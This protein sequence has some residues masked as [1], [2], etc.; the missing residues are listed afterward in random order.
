MH[1]AGYRD[2]RLAWT[3]FAAFTSC[4]SSGNG[5]LSSSWSKRPFF[6]GAGRSSSKSRKG[7]VPPSFL[8][9]RTRYSAPGTYDSL[10]TRDTNVAPGGQAD[11]LA[12]RARSGSRRFC[13]GTAAHAATSIVIG[14]P[15]ACDAALQSSDR[16]S[17]LRVVGASYMSTVPVPR[18]AGT[19]GSSRSFSASAPHLRPHLFNVG[20]TVCARS[21]TVA[22][23]ARAR[24]GFRLLQDWDRSLLEFPSPRIV[25]FLLSTLVIVEP[26]ER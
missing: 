11:A 20:G 4:R 14:L 26:R 16:V 9:A 7:H 2:S 23:W 3:A 12:G 6:G 1:H 17:T 19:L 15:L 13:T 10:E 18:V 25:L 22:G 21:I 24:R 8:I 5:R